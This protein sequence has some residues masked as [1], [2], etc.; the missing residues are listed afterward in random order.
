L[1]FNRRLC[2]LQAAFQ[3]NWID[4]IKL[5]VST[6]IQQVR[7]LSGGIFYGIISADDAAGVWAEAQSRGRFA[8]RRVPDWLF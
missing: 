8:G 3:N 7:T 2:Q 4:I 5:P 6:I 1:E